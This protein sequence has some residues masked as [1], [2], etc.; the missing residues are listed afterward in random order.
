MVKVNKNSNKARSLRLESRKRKAE[1]R[2]ASRVQENKLIPKTVIRRKTRS[3]KP[4]IVPGNKFIQKNHLQNHEFIA[5]CYRNQDGSIDVYLFNS[6]SEIICS[7]P[8]DKFKAGLDASFGKNS[9]KM[10]K[11]A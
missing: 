5:E 8:L 6:A 1:S 9:K 4:Q 11:T 2:K 7:M 3:A 10:A